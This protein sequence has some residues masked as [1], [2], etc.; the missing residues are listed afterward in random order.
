MQK[1]AE[2]DIG[3]AYTY[4]QVIVIGLLGRWRIY[5]STPR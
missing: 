4:S 5:T 1:A 2:S 3:K